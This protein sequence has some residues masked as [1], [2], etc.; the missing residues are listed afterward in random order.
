M[1]NKNQH[2]LSRHIPDDVKSKIRVNSKFGCVVPNCRNPFYEYEHII[3]EFKDA[4][5]HDPD[6]M[7]LVCPQHNPRKQGKDGQEMFSKEQLQKY[8]DNL[9][10]SNP[11]DAP[12]PED[13]SFFSG[14]EKPPV[15]QIGASSFENVYSIINIDSE[16]LLSFTYNSDAGPFEPTILFTGA[17]KNSEG[18][19]VFS[20][21]KNHWKISNSNH[22]VTVKNGEIQIS[23][24]EDKVVFGMKKI[25][26]DNSIEIT[27]LDL[28]YPPFR[29]FIKDGSL[30]VGRANS[31]GEK[32][33]YVSISG[34]FNHSKCAIYLDSARLKEEVAFY[35]FEISGGVGC[36]LIGNGVHIGKA[37]GQ[38][39][40][41]GGA[42]SWRGGIS[43]YSQPKTPQP[44]LGTQ[45]FVKGVHEERIVEY[46]M[47]KEL[48]YYLEGIK[49]DS[50]PISWG[51]LENGEELYHFAPQK[52]VDFSSMKGFVGHWADDLLNTEFHDYVFNAL[53]IDEDDK[54]NEYHRTVKRYE[55]DNYS[56]VSETNEETGRLIH[57]H[58]YS[59]MSPWKGDY[60]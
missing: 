28:W 13:K 24:D 6:K 60:H 17:F 23:E 32:A 52:G 8:Y 7:C 21:E 9:R 59:G 54:G 46:P 1:S 19:L 51:K 38:I 49:L 18:N 42:L 5:E 2:G 45:Y 41:Q 39:R 33:L 53:V 56:V 14:F 12:T 40:L 34:E 25:P 55:M 35:G 16:D 58:E 43:D 37:G 4:Q 27:H 30:W 15:I 11:E 10:K 26:Q 47:W 57:P 48:E 20:I 22:D 36:T 44:P 50:P 29:V 3:P 31:S